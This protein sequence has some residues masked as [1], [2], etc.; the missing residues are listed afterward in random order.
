M[1]TPVITRFAKNDRALSGRRRIAVL[2]ATTVLA[3]GIQFLATDSAWACGAPDVAATSTRTAQ[4]APAVQ[5]KGTVENGFFMT[6]SLAITAGGSKVEI[7]VEVVNFTGAPYRAVTPALALYNEKGAPLRTQDLT[8]EVG[9]P[10]GW[11]K[12]SLVR[13]CDPNLYA[14]GKHSEPLAD[15]RAAHF[16]F[17]VGLSAKA[18]ADL[19]EIRVGLAA[20]TEGGEHAP[21]VFKTMSVSFP[22]SK[23]QQPTATAK[24]TTPARTAKP[25]EPAKPA[26][27][28][29][30]KAA[31]PAADHT[32]AK[33]PA[34]T[35]TAAPATTAPAGTPELAQTGASG[36]DTFLAVSSAALL[37]LGAGVLLAVRRLR[38]QR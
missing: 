1:R 16:T 35:P 13:G 33:A 7:P 3:G 10:K 29:P 23:P 31:E 28:A 24:P 34:A 17:R 19:H 26:K 9:G 2:A 8:V 5:H 36:T 12:V 4:T 18:P 15:G 38:H 32:P 11:E 37:A 25:A 21:W 27:P 6:P 30:T 22:A 20:N 14:V